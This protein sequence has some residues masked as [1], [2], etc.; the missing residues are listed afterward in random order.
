MSHPL[1]RVEVR[2]PKVRPRF[3]TG[4]CIDAMTGSW[5][6]GVKGESMCSGGKAHVMHT[7][8]QGNIGKSQFVAAIEGAAQEHYRIPCIWR[9]N[10]MSGSIARVNQLYRLAAPELMRELEL[11]NVDKDSN[12]IALS[13]SPELFLFTDRTRET[14]SDWADGIKQY[15]LSCKKKPTLTYKTPFLDYDNKPII[16]Q[17]PISMVLDSMSEHMPD[18]AQNL[19]ESA[20]AGHKDGNMLWMNSGHAK[21]QMLQEWAYHSA[22]GGIYFST[23]IHVGKEHSLD[24]R[25]PPTK[26][27]KWLKNNLKLKNA[28]EKATFLSNDIWYI[29]RDDILINDTTK[30]PQWPRNALENERKNSTDLK[31]LT[32][33]NLRGKSGPSG[34]P[35]CVVVSQEQGIL[36][37]L[38]DWYWLKQYGDYGI[39]EPTRAFQSLELYPEVKVSRTTIRSLIQE[40][41]KLKRALALTRALLQYRLYHIDA[42][43][44]YVCSPATLY[45]DIKA[46][47][48][49]W[50]MILSETDDRWHPDQYE[51]KFLSIVDLLN[52]RAG[53]YAPYWK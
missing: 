34:E 38:T 15:A 10:E 23:T 31:V 50:D 33:G 24:P 30:A 3:N 51:R 40:D 16:L 29:M 27:L 18:R 22:I 9:C 43:P 19:Q 48:Y 11:S 6:T 25:Q 37:G 5:F 49:D 45:T 12:Y 35:F 1:M 39:I 21:T 17:T 36:W 26:L 47:G 41:P 53:L 32:I 20:T 46:L 42:D 4:T 52:I 8:G 7:C 44:A 14:C 28:P 2:A 13:S